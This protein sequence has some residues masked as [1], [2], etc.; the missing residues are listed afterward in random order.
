MPIHHKTTRKHPSGFLLFLQTCALV[1]A[2]LLPA[3]ATADTLLIE[4]I[5][6]ERQIPMPQRGSTM[7]QVRSRYG[8]PE[9]T[10]GPVGEPPITTWVYSEFTCYFEHQ[11]VIDCV[12]N[13]V[14]PLEKGP[15]PVQ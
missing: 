14:S 7:Q 4:R 6:K 9:S 8:E 13:K 3:L 15:K 2:L 11:W 12:A 5:Q 1:F 10:K